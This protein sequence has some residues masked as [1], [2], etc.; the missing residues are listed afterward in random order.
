MR[1]ALRAFLVFMILATLVTLGW[2]GGLLY[3]HLRIGKAVRILEE[4]TTLSSPGSNHL[5]EV[6]PP[7]EG[8]LREAGCRALPYLTRALDP[9]KPPP[10]LLAASMQ[11]VETLNLEPAVS[12]EDCD[13]RYKRREAFVINLDDPADLRR[14]KCERV[15]GWWRDHG[16]DA[17]QWWRFWSAWCGRKE[18]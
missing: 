1:P 4:G 8:T 7:A 16:N 17:H 5:L 9:A 10:F 6:P 2:T 11:F 18:G 3:W 15:K 13:L 12:K 14:A